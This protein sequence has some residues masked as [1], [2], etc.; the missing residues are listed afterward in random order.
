[1]QAGYNV[2]SHTI[3]KRTLYATRYTLTKM[4]G[5]ADLW[6]WHLWYPQNYPFFVEFLTFMGTQSQ[7]E[8]IPL[9]TCKP[10]PFLSLSSHSS[11]DW[12]GYLKESALL[13]LLELDIVNSAASCCCC[14][15]RFWT[16]EPERK[17]EMKREWN[18]YSN[19]LMN[20]VTCSILLL[21]SSKCEGKRRRN[22]VDPIM[23][24][25]QN[26]FCKKSR[27]NLEF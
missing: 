5:M 27:S 22:K 20:K 8:V 17:M 21:I 1:M 4:S 24:F 11:K 12:T 7:H 10:T 25:T 3:S 6:T 2:R 19:L 23:V 26:V 18:E 13:L 14:P 16:I 9:A 15:T